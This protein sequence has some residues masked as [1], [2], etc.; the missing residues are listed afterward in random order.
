[1]HPF[2]YLLL[3]GGSMYTSRKKQRIPRSLFSRI[4]LAA[5]C[6]FGLATVQSSS[7]GAQ[8]S[9][10]DKSNDE[11]AGI[12]LKTQ[13]TSKEVGLPVYP[14]AK[15]HKDDKNESA[16][17][18]LGLWGGAFGFKLVLM[19][20]ESGDSPDKIAAFYQKALRKYGPVLDCTKGGT[21]SEKDS[22]KLTCDDDKPEPGKLVFKSGT[23]EKQH[24]V[25]IQQS[26]A[27]STFQLVYVEARGGDK[28]AQ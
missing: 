17:A 7:A 27:G 1:M 23:K 28:E 22:N 11:G 12:V 15:P 4:A 20:M 9:K 21:N 10:K 5:L 25:G 19:K 16:A 2:A 18:N 13:A 8:D 3:S 14:G 24:V 6:T 26:G